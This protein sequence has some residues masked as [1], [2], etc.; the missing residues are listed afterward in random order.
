[1]QG[2]TG[3]VV[4]SGGMVRNNL[5][6]RNEQLLKQK[7]PTSV[8]WKYIEEKC[9]NVPKMSVLQKTYGC[10]TIQPPNTDTH[11]TLKLEVSKNK[12]KVLS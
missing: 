11:L 9:D 7:S 8:G 12:I 10:K 5:V 1:M 4:F 2:R 6:K 3:W